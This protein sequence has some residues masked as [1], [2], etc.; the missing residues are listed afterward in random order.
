LYLHSHAAANEVVTLH[1]G[2]LTIEGGIA[3]TGALV[4]RWQP[5]SGL[6]LEAD[7]SVRAPR[8]RDHLF[9]RIVIACSTPS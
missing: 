8:H 9:R 4:L 7:L 1:E 2:P 6:R 3:G 5:S